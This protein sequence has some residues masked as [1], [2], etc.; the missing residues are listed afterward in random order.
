MDEPRNQNSTNS[1]MAEVLDEL[2][3]LR[4]KVEVYTTIIVAVVFISSGSSLYRT[5]FSGA[6]NTGRSSQVETWNSA[7]AAMDKFDYDKAA[8]IV[9]RL[10]DKNPNYYYGYSFLGY[11]ALER[12]DLREAE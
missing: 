2:K 5:Y 11:I 1:A 3:R 9:R 10:I 8:A 6:S 7:H 4:S 12:N